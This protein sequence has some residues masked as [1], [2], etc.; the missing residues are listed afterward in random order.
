MS[1]SD[2]Q[3]WTRRWRDANLLTDDQVTAITRYE[4]QMARADDGEI[5]LAASHVEATLPRSLSVGT[6][7]GV[8]IGLV[9]LLASLTNVIGTLTPKE[10]IPGVLIIGG[11]FAALGFFGAWRITRLNVQ[12]GP[13]LAGVLDVIGALGVVLV[14]AALIKEFASKSVAHDDGLLVVAVAALLLNGYLWRGANRPI[15]LVA[16]AVSAGGIFGGLL[17]ALRISGTTLLWATFFVLLAVLFEALLRQNLEPAPLLREL[18]IVA[19]FAASLSITFTWNLVGLT[20]MGVVAG[21]ALWEGRVSNRRSLRGL[22]VITAAVFVLW[23]AL[24]SGFR[25]ALLVGWVFALTAIVVGQ[26]GFT[27]R[28]N[29]FMPDGV[30]T[31]VGVLALYA[32]FSKSVTLVLPG[33]TVFLVFGLAIGLVTTLL[34]RATRSRKH[35]TH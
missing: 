25:P 16:T 5:T 15:Q 14:L 17:L 2:W 28:T 35:T 13:T 19:A 21:Y 33:A 30:T 6:V 27:W 1:A 7:V 29:R 11:L 12:Q 18:T 3:S 9:V 8:T 23:C 24:G 20:V 4:L 31:G 22:G 10:Q 34:L 32:V 26:R